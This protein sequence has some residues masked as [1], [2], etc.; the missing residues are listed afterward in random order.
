MCLCFSVLPNFQCSLGSTICNPFQEG[1]IAGE[2]KCTI[3][4][5]NEMKMN[6]MLLLLLMIMMMILRTIT[7]MMMIWVVEHLRDGWKYGRAVELWEKLWRMKRR[8]KLATLFLLLINKKMK[9]KR[10]W[11]ANSS[12]LPRVQLQKY[13]C[14]QWH[15][16]YEQLW[17]SDSGLDHCSYF[18]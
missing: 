11:T 12:Y 15:V 16:K 14:D 17:L 7:M 4:I 13:C 8:H 3:L 5:T 1:N 18:W 10:W 6:M 9:R 2:G